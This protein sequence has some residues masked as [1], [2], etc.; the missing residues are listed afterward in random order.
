MEVI[1]LSD[2]RKLPIVVDF[3]FFIVIGR[4][5][6]FFEVDDLREP[7]EFTDPNDYLLLKLH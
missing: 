4:V 6:Y 1:L 7:R 5:L 2:G 3:W